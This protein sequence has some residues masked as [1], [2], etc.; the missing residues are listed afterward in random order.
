M[1]GQGRNKNRAKIFEG[2]E[3]IKMEWKEKSGE[4]RRQRESG[5]KA[6]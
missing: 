3:R 1:R 5:K 4:G 6:T 2:K